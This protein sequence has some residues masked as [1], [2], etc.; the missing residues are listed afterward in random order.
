VFEAVRRVGRTSIAVVLVLVTAGCG[1]SNGFP[2]PGGTIETAATTSAPQAT[3]GTTATGDATSTSSGA[4][5]TAATTTTTEE[6][7]TTA[8]AEPPDLFAVETL[9]AIEP[10]APPELAGVDGLLGGSPDR[11]MAA[12]LTAQLESAGLDL[13]GLEIEVW[14]ITGT[15][16][17]LLVLWVDD[18][19]TAFGEDDSPGKVLRDTGL[20]S[21]LDEAHITRLVLNYHTEDEEG[22][23]VLT[24]TVSIEVLKEAE[25][26]GRELTLAD[27]RF[28]VTR[29]EA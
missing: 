26:E 28:Q 25:E 22:P 11:A 19:S 9:L 6:P 15:R 21:I 4:T 3:D 20:D 5:T 1:D 16:S 27:M 2:S 12:L 18:T 13:A 14:P 23:L 10:T 24:A 17:S 8:E 29:R 7:T